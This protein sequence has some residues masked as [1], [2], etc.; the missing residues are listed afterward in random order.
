MGSGSTGNGATPARNRGRGGA[1]AVSAPITVGRLYTLLRDEVE[2]E[3]IGDDAGLERPVPG[4]EISSP[5]LA[6]AGYVKRFPA[7][8]LQVFGET[9]ITYLSSLSQGERD[10]I[11]QL[12]FG[13]PIPCV[14][15][16]K[17]QQL[18]EGLVEVAAAGGV[19]LLRSTLK[20]AEFYRRVKTILEGEFAPSTAL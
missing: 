4:A 16:T 8:R 3:L 2:L 1:P 19:P 10:R 7:N 11:L 9:E 13:F 6:L 14:F 20:T 5:G 15:V 18:P 12:F 17:A